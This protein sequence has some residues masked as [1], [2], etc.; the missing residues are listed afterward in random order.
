MKEIAKSGGLSSRADSFQFSQEELQRAYEKE[1]LSGALS[2]KF[3]QAQT[4]MLTFT[5]A[6]E[7]VSTLATVDTLQDMGL[8]EAKA[9]EANLW[10]MNF[11]DKGASALSSILRSVV[12]FANA[13]VQ[14]ARSTTRGLNTKAGWVNFFR[15]NAI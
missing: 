9:I 10:F 12:P 8:S 4:R 1:G 14:G 11:N 2:R 3:A 7:M 13:T 6:M 15:Q 5:T